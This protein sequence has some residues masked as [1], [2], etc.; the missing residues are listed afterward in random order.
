MA[1]RAFAPRLV[2]T[3][4]A[5]PL[6]ALLLWLGHWQTERADE[7]RAREAAFA[8]GDAPP[9]PL[10]PGAGA[11]RY[12][13]VRL[14]G[15]YLPDR[16]FLLDNMTAGGRAGYRVLTPFVTDA[17]VAVL[18][19]RG[20]VPLGASRAARPDV[21]VGG[22]PRALTGRLDALPRAGI[23][24]PPGVGAGWPRVLNYPAPATLAAALGRP[25]YPWI[26]LLD[27]GV[28]D[29]YLRDWRP[30]DVSVGRHLAYAAQWYALAATL[31]VLCVV[32]AR[33]RRERA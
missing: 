2:P 27:P 4:V 9:V 20:W 19:D 33:R 26:V 22:E 8:A 12:L 7:M 1:P 10:P 11:P 21:A 28:P 29:G 25:L 3:L 23:E 5:L 15:L 14:S 31:L 24:P 13:H 17:G 16:Q 18:I 30:H 32:V 6:L